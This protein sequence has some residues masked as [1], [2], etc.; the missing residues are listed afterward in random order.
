M[1]YPFLKDRRL[2][3]DIEIERAIREGLIVLENPKVYLEERRRDLIQPASMDLLLGEMDEVAPIPGVFPEKVYNWSLHPQVHPDVD[4][5]F[6]TF[7][8]QHELNVFAQGLLRFNPEFVVPAVERRSTLGRGGLD[9]GFINLG[10][11]DPY[12]YVSLRNPQGYPISIQKGFKF[13][14]ILWF[15]RTLRKDKHDNYVKVNPDNGIGSGI[16]ITS[17]R[18]LEKLF[19]SG[20]LK[21][22]PKPTFEGEFLVLH[23]SRKATFNEQK[24]IIYRVGAK[25]EGIVLHSTESDVHEIKHGRFLDIEVEEKLELSDRVAL[26]IMYPFDRR[27]RSPIDSLLTMGSSG[28]WVDPKY[29][30]AFSVQKK[31]FVKP[32]KIRVGDRVAYAIAYFF[33]NG[34]G[35]GYHAGRGSHYNNANSF[36]APRG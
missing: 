24:H 12:C 28:G 22:S 11:G 13:A 32:Y 36:S 29:E 1:Q 19:E 23:A 30:G 27:Y 15:E 26:H 9:R 17:R 35:E 25:P 21:V 8:P 33:P 18:E 34:V 2:L 14:Q 31:S 7:W 6:V 16:P 4:D 20:D 5:N 3:N 10:Y